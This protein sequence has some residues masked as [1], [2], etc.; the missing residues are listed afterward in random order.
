MAHLRYN[1]LQHELAHGKLQAGRRTKIKADLEKL[2]S[3]DG[4]W[5]EFKGVT[6]ITRTG[7]NG[8]HLLNRY[9]A[10]FEST[11]FEKYG[12]QWTT[13]TL[14]KRHGYNLCDSHGAAIKKHINSFAKA[15]HRPETA[16]DFAN[17]INNC[18]S[19]YE[20]QI[21]AFT[22]NARTRAYP[23]LHFDR[24]RKAQLY[25]QVKARMRIPH[26]HTQAYKRAKKD[27]RL[28]T[29]AADVAVAA[30]VMVGGGGGDAEVR[31]CRTCVYL[32]Q[33]THPH[34]SGLLPESRACANSSTTISWMT[35]RL[36]GPA[37][38]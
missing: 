38:W 23:I 16:Q 6:H 32:T 10:W 34:R 27:A 5:T 14:C 19:D 29:Q 17:I 37:E 11:A 22:Y 28:R 12:I 9:L 18:T 1:E 30:E 4:Y 31:H 36:S 7:D 35:G 8:G 33:K 25:K 13:H 20:G 2:C 15:D 24:R 21:L 3:Y 26:V